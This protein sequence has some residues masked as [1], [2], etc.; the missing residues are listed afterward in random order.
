M[1]L[2]Q[3]KPISRALAVFLGIVIA[4]L[5]SYGAFLLIYNATRVQNV[6]DEIY[7]GLVDVDSEDVVFQRHGLYNPGDYIWSY[8]NPFKLGNIEEAGMVKYDP[9]MASIHRRGDNTAMFGPAWAFSKFYGNYSFSIPAYADP[10]TGYLVDGEVLVQAI[11]SHISEEG[12]DLL[13]ID[14]CVYNKD[15]AERESPTDGL[16]ADV[17]LLYEP[18]SKTMGADV[19]ICDPDVS[20]E[21]A[22]RIGRDALIG[23]FLPEYFGCCASSSF[24]VDDLGDFAWGDAVPSDGSHVRLE[25]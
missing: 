4:I 13:E 20:L 23:V 25:G 9:E 8:L 1:S 15:Y 6:F 7:W 11:E 5:I 16:V 24:S 22:Y 21:E 14:F 12:N 19:L 17:T 2:P 3:K 10:E 18:G